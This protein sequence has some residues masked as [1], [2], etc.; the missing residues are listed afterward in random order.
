MNY[1]KWTRSELIQRIESLERLNQHLL[2]AEQEETLLQFG[3]SGNLGHWYWD[4]PTNSVTFNPLKVTTLGFT[5][6]EIPHPVTYQFF[7]SRLHPEDYQRVM[8]NMIQ[9]LQGNTHVY[10]VEY[11]IQAKMEVISGI[12]IVA[13]LL[14]EM[15]MGKHYFLRELCSM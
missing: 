12:T 13:P 1:S 8:D 7:T 2:N 14:N 9:H 3:W 11:R 15:S 6:D 10:E 5:M 4:V